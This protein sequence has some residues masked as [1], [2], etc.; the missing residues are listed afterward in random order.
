MRTQVYAALIA[1]V[2]AKA[3]ESPAQKVAA[4]KKTTE[5]TIKADNKDCL[6]KASADN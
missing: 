5:A 1:V 3:A 6:G 4:V 2:A